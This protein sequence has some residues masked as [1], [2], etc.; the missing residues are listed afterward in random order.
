MDNEKSFIL[1]KEKSPTTLI[2]QI[3]EKCLL[4]NEEERDLN[5]FFIKESKAKTKFSKE[6]IHS[7]KPNSSKLITN[8][9]VFLPKRLDIFISI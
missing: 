5:E 8:L 9:Q 1:N 2:N 4:N 6:S 7:N 3:K